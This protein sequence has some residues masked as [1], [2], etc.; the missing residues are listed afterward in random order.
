[1]SALELQRATIAELKADAAVAALVGDRIYDELPPNPVFPYI[2][3][4]PDQTLPQ[5]FDCLDGSE[6]TLQFDGWSRQPGYIEA[7]RISEAVRRCL[8]GAPLELI[9]YRLIDLYLASSQTLR[10]PDGL[11]SHA[12]ITFRALTA[13]L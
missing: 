5:R 2:S 9:G 3:I 7:K 1:M 10:D 11:T 8:D 13:P 12:V 6:I 4:G